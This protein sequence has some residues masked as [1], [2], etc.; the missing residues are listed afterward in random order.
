[1]V[2]WLHGVYSH[3]GQYADNNVG[4]DQSIGPGQKL[5]VHHSPCMANDSG[6]SLCRALLKM[7]RDSA[8]RRNRGKKPGHKIHVRS[9]IRGS[10]PRRGMYVFL[11][12]RVAIGY[13]VRVVDTSIES[14]R[15]Y[16]S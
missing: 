12:L 15:D 14:G 2:E 7:L 8:T 5:H 4:V 13:M 6:S 11:F 9:T 10:F 1:M 16:C 3:V